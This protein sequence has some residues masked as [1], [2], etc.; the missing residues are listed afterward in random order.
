MQ[1]FMG[2]YLYSLLIILLLAIRGQKISQRN[3][4]YEAIEDFRTLPQ[5]IL[6]ALPL[7]ERISQKS[8]DPFEKKK[9]FL[10]KQIRKKA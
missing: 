10:L 2:Y 5:K 8:Y 4:R 3:I 1:Q 6:L 7:S 9:N